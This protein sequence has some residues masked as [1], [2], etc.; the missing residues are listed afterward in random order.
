MTE[1]PA[2][3]LRLLVSAGSKHGSTVEIAHRIGK[4]IEREGV[5]VTVLAPEDAFDLKDFDAIVLGSAVYAGHWTR[6]ALALADRIS[7]LKPKPPVWVFS[8]GP[9]GNPPKPEEDP[10]DVAGVMERSGAIEHNVFAGK[11]DRTS[12]SL[13]EKA[14]VMALKA[15]EGD[16]RDWDAID[17]WARAIASRLVVEVPTR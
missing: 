1:T 6:D 13:A 10:V 5:E 9:V 11:I 14:I 2:Q 3:R 4:T 17:S 12:L 7:V 16:F 8:S 15:P